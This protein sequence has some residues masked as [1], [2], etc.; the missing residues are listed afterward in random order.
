M[1]VRELHDLGRRGYP[2]KGRLPVVLARLFGSKVDSST[3]P[4]RRPD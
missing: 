4:R 2:N 1:K 3:C